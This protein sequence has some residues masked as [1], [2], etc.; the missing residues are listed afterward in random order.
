MGVGVRQGPEAAEVLDPLGFTARSSLDSDDASQS[1]QTKEAEATWKS[2]GRTR[3]ESMV[4]MN[5]FLFDLISRVFE[6]D[7]FLPDR[8]KFAI[9]ASLHPTPAVCGLPTEVALLFIENMVAQLYE[10]ICMVCD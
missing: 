6:N 5:W 9:L 4:S 3:S 2:Q 10:G 1:R 8:T 7:D